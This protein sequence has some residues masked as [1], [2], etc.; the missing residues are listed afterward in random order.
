V[1]RLEVPLC[2]PKV[3]AGSVRAS[4]NLQGWVAFL[5]LGSAHSF[6]AQCP[7]LSTPGL[8]DPLQSVALRDHEGLTAQ[9]SE[10]ALEILRNP[11]KEPSAAWLEGESETASQGARTRV[12]NIPGCLTFLILLTWRFV[13]PLVIAS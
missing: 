2:L 7:M 1:I 8:C 12:S 5:W 11:P 13:D 9:A 3:D 10:A 4:S 6:L